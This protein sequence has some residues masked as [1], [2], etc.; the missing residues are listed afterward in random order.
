MIFARKM[1]EFYVIIGAENISFRILGGGGTCP[2]TPVSHAYAHLGKVIMHVADGQIGVNR[3]FNPQHA[4]ET[5]TQ[6]FLVATAERHLS[7]TDDEQELEE[8]PETTERPSRASRKLHR[9]VELDVEGHVI[10]ASTADLNWPNHLA[11]AEV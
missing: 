1:F 5:N 9:V 4:I 8:E 3:Y 6:T 7:N 11:L 2:L 10:G